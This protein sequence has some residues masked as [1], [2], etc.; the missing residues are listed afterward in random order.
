MTLAAFAV[1]PPPCHPLNYATLGRAHIVSVA[2]REKSLAPRMT[3]LQAFDRSGTLEGSRSFPT[4]SIDAVGTPHGI[5]GG[6]RAHFVVFFLQ[7]RADHLRSRTQARTWFLFLFTHLCTDT[8]RMGGLFEHIDVRARK[9]LW[10]MM[11]WNAYR[12]RGRH[13]SI[14]VKFKSASE[15][16]V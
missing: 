11:P 12:E 15:V 8:C 9:G 7:A 2:F 10:Y 1:A 14:P 13:P 3:W 16:P 6:R 5:Y 4:P